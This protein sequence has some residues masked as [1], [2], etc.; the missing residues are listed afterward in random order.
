MVLRN[1][2]DVGLVTSPVHHPDLEAVSLFEDDLAILAYPA[3]PLAQRGL[4]TLAELSQ[5]PLILFP[6]GSGY[7][8]DLDRLFA[9]AGVLPR[10]TM[11]LDSIEAIKKLVEIG[12]GLSIIPRVAATEEIAAGTLVP[13][14]L[15][16]APVLTR[17]TRLIYRR[18][19]HLSASIQA[20]LE[21]LQHR[22]QEAGWTR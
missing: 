4:T 22:F 20:L 2:V 17:Q 3:H 21:V 7:R 12:L 10:P 5:E 13:V 8:M 16:D 15:S 19:K 9:A 14:A 1:S 6:P 18:D 11:E